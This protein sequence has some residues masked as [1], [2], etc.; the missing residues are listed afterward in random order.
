MNQQR[1]ARGT[2]ARR[3]P[4]FLAAILTFVM[5]LSA[6]GGGG[7]AEPVSSNTGT[8]GGTDSGGKTEK[9]YEVSLFY[10]GTPQKD[11]ALVEAEINKY[12]EPK[13]GATLKINAIDWGQWD[14]KLN[15]MISSGR[16]RILSLR[17]PG[18]IT[19]STWRRAR[20]CR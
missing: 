7:E 19:Q 17:Q 16:N 9:P 1:K 4:L 13:I 2:R 6:C 18:R 3:K 8:S 14:N 10:P 11:V 5:V 15:L 20:S 12:M